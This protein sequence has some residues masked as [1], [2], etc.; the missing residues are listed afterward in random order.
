MPATA[1]TIVPLAFVLSRDEVS[2]KSVVEPVF[3]TENKV[4]VADAVEEPIA[5]NIGFVP[6]LLA[7]I[8]NC[9]HGVEEPTPSAPVVGSW[10]EVEVA[11]SVPKRMLPMLSWLLAVEEGKK[12]SLPRPMLPEPVVT[13]FAVEI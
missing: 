5:N 4:E 12:S 9:D 6:P 3:D 7:W 11:G 8:A 13:T 1:A 10:K 2:W